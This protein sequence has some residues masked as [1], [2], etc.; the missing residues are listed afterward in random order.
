MGNGLDHFSVTKLGHIIA[1]SPKQLGDAAAFIRQRAHEDSQ[2][3]CTWEQIQEALQAAGIEGDSGEI[4]TRGFQGVDDVA[5]S[6]QHLEG[7]GEQ[8][9]T[10]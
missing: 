1:T 5:C 2:H 9:S 3:M 4:K 7:C 6:M 8:I 10:F